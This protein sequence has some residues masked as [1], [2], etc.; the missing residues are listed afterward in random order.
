MERMKEQIQLLEIQINILSQFQNQI[1]VKFLI[2]IKTKKL[3]LFFYIFKLMAI[4]NME[5]ET[6]F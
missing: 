1:F 3:Q 4:L 2:G 5:G 6:C